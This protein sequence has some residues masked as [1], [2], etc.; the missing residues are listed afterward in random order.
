MLRK[1]LR[2]AALNASKSFISVPSG[3]SLGSCSRLESAGF[4]ALTPAPVCRR[5]QASPVQGPVSLRRS[6]RERKPVQRWDPSFEKGNTA[7]L[8]ARSRKPQEVS[9]VL[10]AAVQGVAVQDPA[11]ERVHVSVA[12]AQKPEDMPSREDSL[13]CSS[14][15]VHDSSRQ[16][17]AQVHVLVTT[18]TVSP[19]DVSIIQATDREKQANAK[20]LNSMAAYLFRLSRDNDFSENAP[21]CAVLL[22]H[23]ARDTGAL[24]YDDLWMQGILCLWFSCN[25]HSRPDRRIFFW[26]QSFRIMAKDKYNY[27]LTAN[28]IKYLKQWVTRVASG[29][30]STKICKPPAYSY[31]Q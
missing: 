28:D 30:H 4:T 16:E 18:P 26:E 6:G 8:A 10:P 3:F 17:A 22:L 7:R 31:R 25:V 15:G 20:A 24:R 11:Q 12:V 21:R 14:A 23:H 29:I 13:V 1:S 9:M 5:V 27:D 2:I 19:V